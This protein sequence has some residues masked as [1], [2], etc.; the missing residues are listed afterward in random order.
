MQ[1]VVP[2]YNVYVT[3]IFDTKNGE[4]DKILGDIVESVRD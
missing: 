1:K 2:D 3:A 4:R